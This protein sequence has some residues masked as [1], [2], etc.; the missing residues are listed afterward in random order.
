VF[1]GFSTHTVAHQKKK[2]KAKLHAD[3]LFVIFRTRP[4]CRAWGFAGTSGLYCYCANTF[5]HS[6]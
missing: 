6:F 5:K 4:V 1:V 2:L 3:S